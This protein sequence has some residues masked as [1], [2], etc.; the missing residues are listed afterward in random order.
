MA[1]L[2]NVSNLLTANQTS[3]LTTAVKRQCRFNTQSEKAFTDLNFITFN[4][5]FD[6]FNESFF[7]NHFGFGI[8]FLF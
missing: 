6:Q 8:Q 1:T 5:N 7:G 3:D 2:V 4:Q